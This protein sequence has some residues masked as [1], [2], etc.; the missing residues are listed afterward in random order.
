MFDINLTSIS[1][2]INFTRGKFEMVAQTYN[3]WHF[4]SQVKQLTENQALCKKQHLLLVSRAL[5]M[6][7]SCYNKYSLHDALHPVPGFSCQV[8]YKRHSYTLFSLIEA[9]KIPNKRPRNFLAV[10]FYSLDDYNISTHLKQTVS[11]YFLQ[12]FTSQQ[13]NYKRMKIHPQW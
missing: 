1:Q 2:N 9:I 5:K 8:Q 7:L 11:Y 10:V 12:I 13:Q 4:L 6:L 3:H